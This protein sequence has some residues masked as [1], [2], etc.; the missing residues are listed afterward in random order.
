[1][2]RIRNYR[3][4]NTEKLTCPMCQMLLSAMRQQQQCVS[5]NT[6]CEAKS[7]GDTAMKIYTGADRCISR[8]ELRLTSQQRELT[9]QCLEANYSG[10]VSLTSPGFRQRNS[11]IV[12]FACMTP[13]CCMSSGIVYKKEHNEHNNGQKCN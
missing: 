6:A 1:M 10:K 3:Q 2:A 8:S 13:S 5:S 12:V 7:H 9:G 11:Y 4:T